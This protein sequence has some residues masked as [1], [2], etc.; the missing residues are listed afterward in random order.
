MTTEPFGPILSVAPFDTTDE[1]VELANRTSYGLASYVFTSSEATQRDIVDRL[2]GGTVSI[3]LLNGVAPDA[4][5]TGTGDSGYGHE[6]GE[7][8]FR[9]FQNI[10]LVNRPG[11]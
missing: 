1:A 8:G 5:L 11:K 2:S 7:Q 3:N 4:P 9:A 10:K 6:G